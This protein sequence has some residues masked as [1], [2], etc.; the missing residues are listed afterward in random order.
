MYF[1]LP[2]D[3]IRAGATLPG[4]AT[5]A[6]GSQFDGTSDDD[7][8]LYQGGAESDRYERQFMSVSNGL[9]TAIGRQLL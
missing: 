5:E 6:A 1:Y 3:C 9:W 8:A 2:I 4:P 7:D